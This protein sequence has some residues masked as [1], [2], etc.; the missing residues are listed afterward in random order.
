M[1]RR[2]SEQGC[3]ARIAFWNR[4]GKCTNC[5]TGKVIGEGPVLSDAFD[6][7]VSPAEI[8]RISEGVRHE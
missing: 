1:T 7:D 2:C 8:V 6:H 4:S 3:D 5:Q